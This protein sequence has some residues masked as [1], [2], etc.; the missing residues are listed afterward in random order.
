[1]KRPIP[2]PKMQPIVKKPTAKPEE[3][4]NRFGGLKPFEFHHIPDEMKEDWN[5]FCQA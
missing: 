3:V 5:G 1:M 4:N 2:V